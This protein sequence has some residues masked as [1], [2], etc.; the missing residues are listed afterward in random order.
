MFP[1]S[2]FLPSYTITD[3]FMVPPPPHPSVFSFLNDP[4]PRSRLKLTE[5]E[6]SLL[7]QSGC[8]KTRTRII[9]NTGAFHAVIVFH[10]NAFFRLIEILQL[11]QSI[12]KKQMLNNHS[13]HCNNNCIIIIF[14]KNLIQSFFCLGVSKEDT[15]KFL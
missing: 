9:P 4:Y 11:L 12:Q 6:V 8:G 14:T 15:A 13:I 3:H 10:M 7:I 2:F 1:L 5:I